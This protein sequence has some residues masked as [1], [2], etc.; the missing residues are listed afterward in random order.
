[1]NPFLEELLPEVLR[2]PDTFG[3]AMYAVDGQ[4]VRLCLSGEEAPP[5]P[6]PLRGVTPVF[7]LQTMTRQLAAFSHDIG[8]GLTSVLAAMDILDDLDSSEEHAGMKAALGEQIQTI[9]ALMRARRMLAF[10]LHLEREPL[11]LRGV[12]EDVLQ[13]FQAFSLKKS[14]QLSLDSRGNIP[15]ISADPG[16]LQ[17]VV[18]QLLLNAIEAS[19]PGASVRLEVRESRE[20]GLRWLTVS[21]LDDGRGLPRERLGSLGEPGAFASHHRAGLGLFAAAQGAAALGAVLW[22]SERRP[23]GTGAHLVLRL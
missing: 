18:G 6:R 15:E 16:V 1:M 14:V 10:P 17:C 9:S 5:P 22:L 12:M 7:L 3:V 20:R 13:T 21:V 2:S 19:E 23:G 8:G 4:V 11:E